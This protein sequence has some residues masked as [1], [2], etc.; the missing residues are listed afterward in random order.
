MSQF[1]DIQLKLYC[2]FNRKEPKVGSRMIPLRHEC[3]TSTF[4]FTQWVLFQVYIRPI[5]LTICALYL[6][7][8][9]Y[10]VITDHLYLIDLNNNSK[11]LLINI[12]RYGVYC[13]TQLNFI[14]FIKKIEKNEALRASVRNKC[15]V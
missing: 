5:V 6:S 1:D 15:N 7:L 12:T 11:T 4:N 8:A 13:R 9:K 10:Y 14:N 3:I 2:K